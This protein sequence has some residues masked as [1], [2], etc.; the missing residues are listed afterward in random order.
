MST[1]RCARAG[2][3]RPVPRIRKAYL[4]FALAAAT[5]S[6]VLMAAP[7][8]SLFVPAGKA[9][10]WAASAPACAINNAQIVTGTGKIISKGAVVFRNGL[11]V[12]VGDN[13]KIPADARVIDGTGLTVYPGLIDGFTSLGLPAP[14]AT[15]PAAG[16]RGGRQAAP[17]APVTP[18]QEEQAHGDPSASVA[19][20][21]KPGGAPVEDERSV[22][23]T[24]ALTTFREGIF[25]GQ[26]ALINLAGDEPSKLVVRAPV[27]LTV[28]FTTSS[29]FFGLYPNSLM[30]T[31]AF[32]RQSFYDAVH[33]RDE[34]DRYERVKRGVPRPEHDKKLAALQPVLRGELP[35][36]FRANSDGDIRR[37]LMIAHE[38]KLKPIIEGALYGYRVA[39]MLKAQSVPVILSVDFPKRSAD[40]PDDETETLRALRERAETPKG[41]GKLAQAGV[42]FA[43]ASGSLR[44]Q[45][46][47]ANVRKAVENGL[48][49]EDA[50]RA[51]TMNAAE[52]LG[53]GDQVGSIETGKIANVIV[54]SGDLLAKDTK[55]R[56]LFID[57]NEVEVK[58]P[59]PPA[60]AGT[61]GQGGP[62]GGGA[63]GRPSL[64]PSGDWNLEAQTPHGTINCRLTLRREGGQILG[65]FE[66]PM[67]P[68][69]IRNASLNGN[70]LR[71]SVTL[72]FGAQTIDSTV[73]GTIEGDSIRGTIT[74]PSMGPFDFSGNRPH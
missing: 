68:S 14:A 29:G 24:A 5:L 64:D 74:V 47:I 40:L 49:K 27:A 11:I 23:V 10:T 2:D 43:F 3:P 33:Y 28:Q 9:A 71:F 67:G 22:G 35:V 36:I 32:I 4:R 69:E 66:G 7:R 50:I 72:S 30:G 31:V 56:Y 1:T 48:S 41:A 6:A 42:K 62:R 44:P 70:Q 15:A 61:G 45:D 57:G 59:E 52:I 25:E 73:T 20:Q 17:P 65:T 58:K 38:F 19:D 63:P 16:G 12:A 46:F 21:V 55:V 34:I 18:Q 26:S 8:G 51:L 37:A 53:A 54:T 13:V 60:R 39:D